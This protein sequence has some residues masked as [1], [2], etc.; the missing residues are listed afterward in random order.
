MTEA[1]SLSFLAAL[2]EVI[3]L[4][5]KAFPADDAA[6]RKHSDFCV[7]T[8]SLLFGMLPSIITNSALAD[9]LQWDA[10]LVRAYVRL[11]SLLLPQL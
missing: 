8:L 9:C 5:A 4:T 10:G 7:K 11:L 1:Q 3:D 2:L 6:L